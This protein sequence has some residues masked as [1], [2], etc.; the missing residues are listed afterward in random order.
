[1]TK[2]SKINADW[3][4]VKVTEN[5][6]VIV[7]AKSAGTSVRLCFDSL[8][9]LKEAIGTKKVS[10]RKWAIS[11]P[12]QNCILKRLTLP[13]ADMDE[14]A[15]MMEFELSSLVPIPP[16]KLVYGCTLLGKQENMLNLLVCIVPL[17]TLDRILAP[18]KAMGIQAT[19]VTPD[20]LSMQ[21]WFNIA[22][23][24]SG[25]I[26]ANILID[27]QRCHIGLSENGHFHVISE[28]NLNGNSIELTTEQIIQKLRCGRE[29]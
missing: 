1:V 24:N 15:R 26:S 9:D 18:Y 19:R 25:G 3:A 29:E 5:G 27:K 23:D 16:E 21:S 13:A 28:M 10:V 11:L 8:N 6:N 4:S 2:P 17:D 20:F 14:A 22:S 12:N 7:C